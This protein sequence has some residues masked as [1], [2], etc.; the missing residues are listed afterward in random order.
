VLSFERGRDCADI[1]DR[2]YAP[3]FAR[4][5]SSA[6]P[7]LRMSC[8][9]SLMSSCFAETRPTRIQRDVEV[10]VGLRRPRVNRKTRAAAL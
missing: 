1:A 5:H 9:R 10:K 8:E 6:L 7:M 3:C 4:K 2:L